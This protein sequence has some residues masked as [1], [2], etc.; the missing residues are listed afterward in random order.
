[1]IEL[2]MDFTFDNLSAD[3]R[4]WHCKTNKFRNITAIFDTGAR[5]SVIDTDSFKNL[6]YK[7]SDARDVYVSTAS[8]HGL[9]V[10]RTVIH[11]LMLGDCELGPVVFDVLNLPIRSCQM[12]LGL[13]VIKEFKTV[14]DFDNKLIQMTPRYNS[15]K[16]PLDKFYYNYSR[17]G[18]SL[19]NSE[20]NLLN[21]IRN[22]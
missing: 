11:D 5:I 13:N 12:L 10:K 18:E 19:L 14:L 4:I 16:I 17:F 9:A 21:N 2:E 20:I 6:G 1:M 8:H 15:E 3:I 7:L 22:K